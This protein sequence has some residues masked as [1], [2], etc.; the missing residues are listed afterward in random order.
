MIGKVNDE[1][2]TCNQHHRHN[3]RSRHVSEGSEIT[4]GRYM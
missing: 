4:S 3:Q 1:V 2:G